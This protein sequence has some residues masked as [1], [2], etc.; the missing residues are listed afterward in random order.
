VND[1]R[2]VTGAPFDGK[3]ARNGVRIQSVRTQPVNRLRRKCN[4]TS[5]AE[6]AYCGFDRGFVDHGEGT[7]RHAGSIVAGKWQEG[8]QKSDRNEAVRGALIT[9][10]C[11]S[12][13]ATLFLFVV[14][15]FFLV[16]L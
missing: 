7:G 2:T 12:S 5:G 14:F 15:L 10:L 16:D 6:K 4:Q 1:Q 8:L 9:L 11:I 13:G 3:N